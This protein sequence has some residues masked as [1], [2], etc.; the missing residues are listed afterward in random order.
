MNWYSRPWLC[1]LRFENKEI[2]YLIVDM[3]EKKRETKI[4]LYF[5]YRKF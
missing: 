1:V 5:Y 2:A 3:A 4:L